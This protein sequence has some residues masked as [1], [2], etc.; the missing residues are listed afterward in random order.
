MIRMTKHR[1]LVLNLFK[2]SDDML[3]AE[4][5]ALLLKEQNIDLSTIYRAL[6]YFERHNMLTKSMINQTSYYYLS[7]DKHF[8][9]LIC[10]SCKKR[11]KLDCV[12]EKFAAETIA[13]NEFKVTHHDL[14][15]YGLCRNCQ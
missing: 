15:I 5:I 6:E 1:K 4:D 14:T 3:C 9:Y 8:H 2:E 13:Q 12:I 10:T 11:Y 7:G